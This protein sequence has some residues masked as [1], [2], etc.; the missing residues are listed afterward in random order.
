MI[1]SRLDEV[2][3]VAMGGVTFHPGKIRHDHS[4][5]HMRLTTPTNIA[6]SSVLAA[7]AFVTAQ[8]HLKDGRVLDIPVTIAPSR[9]RVQLLSKSIALSPTGSA[10]LIHLGNDTDLPQ[11]GRLNFFLKSVAPPEFPRDEK[12]EVASANGGFS[13]TLSLAD[14]SLTLQDAQTVLAVLDPAKAFGPS[15]FGPIRFRPV[16]GDGVNGDWQPLTNL[17]RLP[18]LKEVHCPAS[19]TKPC[20]LTGDNL[21]LIDS[22]S[23]TQQFTRPVVVPMGFAGMT[24]QVPRPIGTTLYLKL[25]DDPATVDLVSLPVMP[26]T[27]SF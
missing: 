12:I 5:E 24:M 27:D 3:S 1:G 4:E 9:P 21:F 17:V 6:G 16:T 25:R 8:V 11:Y 13:T 22:V 2:T 26:E 15:A 10:A 14:A 23:N 19:P 18:S 20:T 7:G